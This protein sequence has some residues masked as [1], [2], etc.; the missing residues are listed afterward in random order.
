[1][2]F[3]KELYRKKPDVDYFRFTLA[4][5]MNQTSGSYWFAP[6]MRSTKAKKAVWEGKP[7]HPETIYGILKLCFR[8]INRNLFNGKAVKLPFVG[9][10]VPR[11]HMGINGGGHHHKVPVYQIVWVDKPNPKIKAIPSMNLVKLILSDGNKN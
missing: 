1:M 9:T 11:R 4:K 6:F 3:R 5:N 2:L 10:F 7:I 8:E